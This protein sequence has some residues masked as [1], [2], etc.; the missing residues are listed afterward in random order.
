MEIPKSKAAFRRLPSGTKLIL[1]R[2][3][4]G[5]VGEARVITSIIDKGRTMTLRHPKGYTGFLP[6]TGEFFNTETTFGFR[7]NGEVSAEYRFDTEAV[8]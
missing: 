2:N 7:E 1:V 6:L 5:D 4:M 8:K 3:Q